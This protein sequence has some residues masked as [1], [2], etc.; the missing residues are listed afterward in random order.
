MKK[1]I[2]INITGGGKK[3]AATPSGA[4][5]VWPTMLVDE[6]P[7]GI[8]TEIA[9]FDGM[10]RWNSEQQAWED[11]S[12]F[13]NDYGNT[14]RPMVSQFTSEP[15]ECRD[16]APFHVAPKDATV[17]VYCSSDSTP[18]PQIVADQFGPDN[19]DAW[20]TKP[21][22]TNAANNEQEGNRWVVGGAF[23]VGGE[24]SY[25]T[26]AMTMLDIH[27]ELKR[28]KDEDPVFGMIEPSMYYQ[29]E[30]EQLKIKY[31]YMV[32]TIQ[33]LSYTA[34]LTDKFGISVKELSKTFAHYIS[35][36]PLVDTYEWIDS[37]FF[38]PFDTTDNDIDLGV[39]GQG[40]FK[41]TRDPVYTAQAVTGKIIDNR[42]FEVHMVPR[43]TAYVVYYKH[44]VR[45][46]DLIE[47][48]IDGIDPYDICDLWLVGQ[49]GDEEEQH[50]Q[51]HDGSYTRGGTFNYLP[52]ETTNHVGIIYGRL[53]CDFS[54]SNIGVGED[55]PPNYLG[56]STE[57]VVLVDPDGISIGTITQVSQESGEESKAHFLDAGGSQEDADNIYSGSTNSAHVIR[58]EAGLCLRVFN[59]SDHSIGQYDGVKND[60][61]LDTPRTLDGVYGERTEN[62]DNSTEGMKKLW[63]TIENS[64]FWQEVISPLRTLAL[65]GEGAL[66]SSRIDMIPY[67]IGICPSKA[68]SLVAAIRVV[69]GE[70]WFVWRAKDEDFDTEEERHVVGA[71]PKGHL[72]FQSRSAD[73]SLEHYSEGA[74][75][76]W[77]PHDSEFADQFTSDGTRKLISAGRVISLA[78][79]GYLHEK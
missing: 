51:F 39:E 77:Q 67:G 43:R 15:L 44:Q 41:V 60:A 49:Y 34:D 47:T 78:D 4:R 50:T 53:P 48:H 1:T 72:S 55:N 16:S 65:N 36:P 25:W 10:T 62:P 31:E 37:L 75:F 54:P 19:P 40:N 17:I 63:A 14:A 6:L 74:N 57:D 70:S 27:A 8:L 20:N 38:C 66:Q 61:F 58:A 21:I 26:T 32:S 71:G 12:E 64:Q 68:G 69:G 22:L 42:K 33:Q 13:Y 45:G 5:E 2:N 79:A 35:G 3:A 46:E 73:G 52:I 9:F 76:D 59:G 23:I 56:H 28:S 24:T 18:D 30:A 11:V 7:P 29:D